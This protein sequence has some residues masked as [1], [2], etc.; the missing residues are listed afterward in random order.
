V[1]YVLDDVHHSIC[2][3]KNNPLDVLEVVTNSPWQIIQR[4]KKKETDVTGFVATKGSIPVSGLKRKMDD[5]GTVSEPKRIKA[6]TDT[7]DEILIP[8]GLVWDNEN[9]SCAYYSVLT[10]LLSVWMQNPS[11]WK[12]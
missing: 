2:W 10:V 8:Q 11:R 12:N 3:T 6:F 5:R 9:Y 7:I 4:A 1:D